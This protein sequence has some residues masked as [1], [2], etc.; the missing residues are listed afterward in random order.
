[1]KLKTL[2]LA[3]CLFAGSQANAQQTVAFDVPNKFQ[4]N[5][6]L[7]SFDIN[8]NFDSL[9]TEINGLK[10]GE[11]KTLTDKIATLEQLVA[12]QATTINNLKTIVDNGNLGGV[13]VGDLQ[14]K[15]TNLE[16]SQGAQDTKITS[17]EQKLVDGSGQP[18][19]LNALTS[20]VNDHTTKITN[21]EQRLV[22]GSGQPI[23]LAGINTKVANLETSQGVQDG[24]LSTLESAVGT[25]TTKITNIEQALDDG[26]GGLVNVRNLGNSVTNNTSKITNIEQSLVDGSGNPID[27]SALQ[28]RV[29]A[30]EGKNTA[31]DGSIAANATAAA[32]ARSIAVSANARSVNNA[33][34]ITANT[35]K[36]A[37]QDTA[38]QAAASAA[39]TAD[40]K[41]VAAQGTANTANSRAVAAQGTAN[42]ANSRAV[43]AQNTA[44]TANSRST[45]NA[46]AITALRAEQT[47][48]NNRLTALE[49]ANTTRGNQITNLSNAINTIN[50]SNVMQLNPY[51]RRATVDGLPVVR[52][53]GA[54]LQMLNGLPANNGVGNGLGNIIIGHN[55][56]INNGRADPIC[57]KNLTSNAGGTTGGIS[58][59]CATAGGSMARYVRTGSHN[60]IIGDDHSY[61]GNQNLIMGEANG[62]N[63]NASF[64]SGFD[65]NG[66]ADYSAMMGGR[67]N[68]MLSEGATTNAGQGNQSAGSNRTRSAGNHTNF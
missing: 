61:V 68:T 22:D 48:Q 39:S 44:N 5:T 1:M 55:T 7:K 10:N 49:N 20:T 4:P 67:Q 56:K 15:V 30:V 2:F 43:A 14:T 8:Q 12:D 66:A 29:T 64:Y 28:N 37:A 57:T 24:K 45:T 47:T 13:N 17:I 46:N 36:N 53:L 6:V 18:I 42:T 52:I 21:I 26:N 23:D 16:T 41:A 25:H 51:F 33:Q 3:C 50:N 38:I 32:N 40:G 11:I 58:T 35:N 9:T 19:D 34:A 65:N 63:A 60:L 59:R 62:A 27:L 54:N 31:Q